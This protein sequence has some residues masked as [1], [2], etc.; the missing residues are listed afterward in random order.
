MAD[1][2]SRLKI[3]HRVLHHVEKDKVKLDEANIST[4]SKSVPSR[5]LVARCGL[6][7]SDTTSLSRYL[8]I[9][10]TNTSVPKI[11]VRPV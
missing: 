5:L 4:R 9:F 11:D 8:V 1:D 10:Q 6:C 3:C 7:S 2:A